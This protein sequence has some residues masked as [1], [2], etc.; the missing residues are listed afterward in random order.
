VD[1]V[2]MTRIQ[3]PQQRGATKFVLTPKVLNEAQRPTDSD[4]S[5]DENHKPYVF[6]A[7]T[8]FV[9]LILFRVI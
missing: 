6:V 2:Y 4:A 7:G 9:L 5:D 3:G 1:V 8:F